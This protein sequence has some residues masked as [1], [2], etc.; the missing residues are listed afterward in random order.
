VSGVGIAVGTLVGTGVGVLVGSEE[1]EVKV[2]GKQ[3]GLWG[4]AE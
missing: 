4:V 1:L 2:E 3:Y